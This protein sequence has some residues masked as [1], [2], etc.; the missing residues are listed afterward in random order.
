MEQHERD[1]QERRRFASEQIPWIDDLELGDAP[2]VTDPACVAIAEVVD[3]LQAEDPFDVIGDGGTEGD[4][5]ALAR[6]RDLGVVIDRLEA[7]RL[8][9]LRAAE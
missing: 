7:E 4:A 9:R 6:L 2:A 8:R 3:G 1:A 5:A